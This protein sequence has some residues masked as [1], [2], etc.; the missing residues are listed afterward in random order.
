MPPKFG[1][2]LFRNLKRE[3]SGEQS[4]TPSPA[5]TPPNSLNLD[6]R[7][8]SLT[9]ADFASDEALVPA[10]A[11]AQCPGRKVEVK[12]GDTEGL[13]SGRVTIQAGVLRRIAGPLV[14]PEIPDDLQLPISLKTVVLQI[15]PY[16]QQSNQGTLRPLGP[17]FDTPIA[18]VAREDEGF[19]KL[20]T[21]AAAEKSGL[22]EKPPGTGVSSPP[23]APGFP[24]IREKPVPP[25]AAE[26][27]ELPAPS[28]PV[29]VGRPQARAPRPAHATEERFDPFAVLPSVGPR[30]SSGQPR[31]SGSPPAAPKEIPGG[32]APPPGVS[33]PVASASPL[34]PP[35]GL[36]SKPGRRIALER[37]QEIFMTDDLLDIAQVLRLVSQF[38]R[39][40]LAFAV[41]RDGIV[42]GEAPA[43]GG[44][45]G[46]AGGL[47]DAARRFAHLATGTECQGITILSERPLSIIGTETLSLILLHEGRALPPG[48]K[49]RVGAIAQAL[50]ELLP[51][52]SAEGG[53][54]A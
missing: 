47:V 20:E 46:L 9:E 21:T 52:A 51:P 1:N 44:Y 25:P 48:M 23:A 6:E 45:A 35:P 39:V 8:I 37:L 18:Q 40:T 29:T 54:P 12:L 31:P 17:D 24:L 15:H 33:H 2:Y 4:S 34:S 7:L 22:D 11:W 16:L 41:A 32:H 10:L 19:F 43:L 27:P 5:A 3:E 50:S 14:P 36:S 30:A 53:A 13:M 38:P 42:Y 28:I 49:E 26:A